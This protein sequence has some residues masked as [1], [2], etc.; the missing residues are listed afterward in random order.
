MRM[1]SAEIAAQHVL[2]YRATLEQAARAG[3]PIMEK[4]LAATRQSL[5]DRATPLRGQVGRGH[6]ELALQLLDTHARTLCEGYPDALTTAF[7]Q[8]SPA[9][10]E[11]GGERPV[12]LAGLRFDQLELM[13]SAAVHETVE[14]ARSQQSAML[15]ADGALTELNTY[16]CATLGMK[17]V[18]PERNPLRPEVYVQAL[19]SLLVQIQVPSL[20]RLDWLQHMSG[21]LG[22]E[23]KLLYYTLSQQLQN[24][25]VT[26]A[27]YAVVRLSPSTGRPVARRGAPSS[28]SSAPASARHPR[29]ELLRDQDKAVLTLDRLR[30]LL[31]GELDPHP[32]QPTESDHESFAARFSRE[33]E[34]GGHA[35]PASDFEA[36]VPA[37]F[38]ALNEMKQVD[39][40][41]DRIGKRRHTTDEGVASGPGS[42]REVRDHLRRVTRSLGQA[43][44]LEVVA[45]MVENIAQDS[46]LL[47]PIREVVKNLE[48][49]LLRL[50]LLDPRFF[51]DKQHPARRLLQEIT[52]RSLAY[53]AV[54]ARGFAGF[55]EPLQ[56]AV[57]PLAGL[58]IEDAQPFEQ[59]LRE[60]VLLWADQKQPRQ[61][62]NAVQAL[63]HAE[64]RNLLAEKIAHEIAA[65]PNA[66]KMP[67]G[68]L[69]FLY[70]PWV[71]VMAHA[72][73][74]GGAGAADPGQYREV[75]FALFWSAQPDLTRKNIEKLT[76]LVPKLLSKLR[77]GLDLID[78]P[79]LKTSA[80]FELLMKLHQQ[81]FRPIAHVAA[82]PP[83]D[84]LSLSLFDDADPWIA[85]AE[86]KVS[87]FM[88]LSEEIAPRPLSTSVH[89]TA[90]THDAV[91]RATAM[92]QPVVASAELALPVGTWIELLVSG[93]WT[94]TQLSWASPH[95]TLFLFTNAYGT[96]QSMTRRS[97]DKL[98]AADTMRIVSGQPVVEVALDAVAQ[99]AMLNSID[100]RL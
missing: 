76:Q 73:M 33:F 16:I 52:H 9:V 65:M 39:L 70:G 30:R 71:Q 17:A 45:L 35:P 99:T 13:D 49:A 75:V 37:A 60:L 61:L 53:D 50:V 10:A 59:V 26:A 12:A 69:A 28:P 78:Y 93:A 8:T 14:L 63:Q 100:V 55:L 54:D 80:F 85:P 40:M 23:L 47:E 67:A 83:P 3:A 24:K 95:G 15:G 68:I 57:G 91:E 92:E 74:T 6:I 11:D 29:D 34:S 87:G 4:M 86:A 46:R 72:R 64:N 44:S 82:P 38:E 31:V 22:T 19:S 21:T 98:L 58:Q 1:H 94:R 51:S 41:I 84:G 88:A 42:P 89:P 25:G 43:L 77:E 79:F 62:A 2:L 18:Q 7:R 81:A 48:P 66:G 36:T 56:R 96:T 90:L 97:R 32:T 27:G 20:V 5:Q